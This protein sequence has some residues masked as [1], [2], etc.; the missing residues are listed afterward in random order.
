M[1][2]QTTVDNTVVNQT[3]PGIEVKVLASDQDLSVPNHLLALL[4]LWAALV[5]IFA[6]GA[7]WWWKGVSP[8]Y[9]GGGAAATVG[10]LTNTRTSSR[11]SYPD[12]GRHSSRWW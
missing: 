6:T 12:Y 1:S 7:Y 3:K 5:V 11:V 9:T 4:L 8:G 10:I 2:E